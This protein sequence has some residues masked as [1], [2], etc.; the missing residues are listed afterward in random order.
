[1]LDANPLEDIGN[2]KKINAVV[3][4]GRLFDRKALDRMLNQAEAAA[5]TANAR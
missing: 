5:N 4:N 1:L 2:T 3:M